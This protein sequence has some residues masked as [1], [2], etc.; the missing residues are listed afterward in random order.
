MPIDLAPLKGDFDR[1]RLLTADELA[2]LSLEFVHLSGSE[3]HFL[4]YEKRHPILGPGYVLLPIPD[5]VVLEDERLV[6][7]LLREAVEVYGRDAAAYLSRTAGAGSAPSSS[8]PA[9]AARPR[10]G[11]SRPPP[12]GRRPGRRA[13][14]TGARDT[15]E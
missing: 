8:A 12:R 1:V 13:P 7:R 2:E 9:S 5:P 6:A 11:T 15:P 14:P 10:R 3:G 4:L